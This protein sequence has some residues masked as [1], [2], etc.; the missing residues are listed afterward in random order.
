MISIHR[1]PEEDVL[2]PSARKLAAEIMKDP[3]RSRQ[4][5]IDCGFIT[6]DGQLHPNYRSDEELEKNMPS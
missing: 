3:I 1:D 6:E 4:F 2:P 5:L